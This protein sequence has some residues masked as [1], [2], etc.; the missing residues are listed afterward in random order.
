MSDIYD[1]TIKR[2]PTPEEAANIVDRYR[3]GQGIE[4]IRFATGFARPRITEA[5]RAA[6]VQMR[7]GKRRG[8]AN[9]NWGWTGGAL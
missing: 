5:I 7:K 2:N 3:R 6:G 8:P 9:R 1:E 4:F